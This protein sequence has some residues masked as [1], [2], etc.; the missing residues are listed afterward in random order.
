MLRRQMYLEYVKK[1]FPDVK[2]MLVGKIGHRREM[3]Y[4][5]T[6]EVTFDGIKENIGQCLRI[7]KYYNIRIK[8]FRINGAL[9]HCIG[10]VDWILDILYE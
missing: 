6:L 1:M 3:L 8:F 7:M 9:Y 4:Y 2:F 10:E 5:S